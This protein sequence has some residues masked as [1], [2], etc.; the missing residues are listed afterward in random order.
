MLI[1]EFTVY[2]LKRIIRPVI[3]LQS[4]NRVIS[5]IGEIIQIP[6]P[7]REK[8]QKQ[9]QFSLR[10]KGFEV[11]F[12]DL[13]WLRGRGPS[14]HIQFRRPATK[15]QA[16]LKNFFPQSHRLM[17][18]VCGE[19]MQDLKSICLEDIRDIKLTSTDINAHGWGHSDEVRFRVTY[20]SGAFN[21]DWKQGHDIS[22]LMISDEYHSGRWF[23]SFSFNPGAFMRSGEKT[24][25]RENWRGCAND[26]S[27]SIDA[28]VGRRYRPDGPRL[29]FEEWSEEMILDFGEEIGP[30]LPTMWETIHAE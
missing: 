20:P 19:V 22:P 7:I 30:K 21:D 23:I 13:R 5:E 3:Q 9:E 8:I 11:F 10:Y 26:I 24:I 18:M 28:S 6:H 16:F 27:K 17:D 4:M 29:S 14:I 12:S 25:L 1:N 2:E 15:S